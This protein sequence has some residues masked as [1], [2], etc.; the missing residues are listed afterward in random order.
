MTNSI[1]NILKAI[2]VNWPQCANKVSPALL[3]LLRVSNLVD[4]K[5]EALVKSHNLQ[6]AE[7][8]ALA[9]L[10]RSPMPYCLS[11][12]ALYQSMVFSSGGLT[13][14]LNRLNQAELIERVDN[15]EDKRS[16][17]VQLT[18]KGKQ[19]IEIVM[20]ELHHKERG[21]LSVL[22][23]DEQQLLDSFM[24]RILEKHEP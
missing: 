22:S 7:F 10:R 20:P 19:L 13:K 3:R 18:N 9:T 16:K 15:P 2:D 12:T 5:I 1:N 23:P 4:N 17:L 24:R 6:R 8:S 11:P 21:V 14:V